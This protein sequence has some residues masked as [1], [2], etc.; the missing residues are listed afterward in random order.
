MKKKIF[1]FN[2]DFIL[3]YFNFKIPNELIIQFNRL[4][5]NTENELLFISGK[6]SNFISN[7][8]SNNN[9]EKFS[10]VG[11][12]GATI[13]LNKQNYFNPSYISSK[14]T[15][16][17]NL[18]KNQLILSFKNSISFQSNSINLTANII[19][20]DKYSD[21]L[22]FIK[23]NKPK[24]ISIFPSEN[25]IDLVPINISKAEGINYFLS[26]KKIDID[27]CY[28]YSF[29]SCASDVPT[30]LLA[31]KPFVIGNSL[32]LSMEHQ[33]IQECRNLHSILDQE[34]SKTN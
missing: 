23:K 21:I 7:I 27:N 5:S 1:C 9:L 11:E 17:L 13:H 20:K 26:L 6:H 3:E 10:I 12:Y 32:N 34:L 29:A 14:L 33:K 25:Y 18:L 31:D 15:N 2:F 19:D 28:I 8:A 30:L 24:K 4:S 16:E 22:S